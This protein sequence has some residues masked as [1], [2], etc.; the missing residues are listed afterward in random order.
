MTDD[1]LWRLLPSE[2]HVSSDL[3]N[4]VI[5]LVDSSAVQLLTLDVSNLLV[6][7]VRL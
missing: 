3:V 5:Q 4:I 6:S 2:L 7:Y 1:G